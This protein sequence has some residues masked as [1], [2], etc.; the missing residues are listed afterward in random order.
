MTQP[1]APRFDLPFHPIRAEL[2]T[3]TE[4]MRGFDPARPESYTETTD[5]R[6]YRYF[7]A[8]GGSAS[9]DPYAGM[10]EALHDNYILRA[11]TE[12]VHASSKPTVAIMGG[13]DESR[14]SATYVEV[15]RISRLLT[16]KGFLVSSGGGPGAMEATH[17]GALL[18]EAPESELDQAVA[19]LAA[20]PRLPAG[21]PVIDNDTGAIDGDAAR[22]LH[23]W[24]RPAYELAAAYE[25]GGVSLG[26]PTWYYGHEPLSPLATN[27][28]KYFQ[29][30]IRED[31]LLLLAANGIIYTPGMSGTLQEIFQNAAQNVRRC[32]DY[33][34]MIFFDTHYWTDV[35]PVVPLLRALFVEGN[36]FTG[37]PILAE[38]EFDRFVMTA[39][40][41][42]DAVAKLLQEEPTK[43]KTVQ[44]ARTLG[45]GRL[46][47]TL[48]Q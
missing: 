40:T 28:A 27:V 7:V 45:F 9:I 37:G 34:P 15:A 24:V 18:A 16:R 14:S 29:N 4:L 41:V 13:H 48:P 36:D 3:S 8:H 22:R 17:L 43:A 44:R 2:Y 19:S 47:A 11:M 33:A 25:T 46:I 21:P 31:I 32:H 35:L 5:F 6:I 42:E 20:V 30:S 1:M 38:A 10:M 26:V 39:D 23:D 12:F